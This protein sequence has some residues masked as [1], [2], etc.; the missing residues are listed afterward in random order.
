MAWS[1]RVANGE[2]NSVGGGQGNPNGGIEVRWATS[3][4]TGDTPAFPDTAMFV[5][6][7]G[8]RISGSELSAFPSDLM[9]DV[10]TPASMRHFMLHNAHHT[11]TLHVCLEEDDVDVLDYE[12]EETDDGGIDE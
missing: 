7:T 8:D 9:G 4:V 10:L 1:Q 5:T 11:S 2:R 12:T 6:V 3:A